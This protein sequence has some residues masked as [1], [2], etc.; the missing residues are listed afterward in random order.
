MTYET[1]M[2]VVSVPSENGFIAIVMSSER[3]GAASTSA[4]P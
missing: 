4:L 2:A 3:S 1:F